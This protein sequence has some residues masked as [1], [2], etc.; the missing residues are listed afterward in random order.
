MT[1]PTYLLYYDYMGDLIRK[2]DWK[3]QYNCIV[4]LVGNCLPNT[5][6]HCS[7]LCDI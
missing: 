5:L 2:Y 6:Q 1:I 7:L 4:M 3:G